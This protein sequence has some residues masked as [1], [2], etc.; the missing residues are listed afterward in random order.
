MFAKFLW[1]IWLGFCLSAPIG[2]IALLCIKNTL[3]RGRLYGLA[4]GMGAA[5]ADGIYGALA[6]CGLGM[7]LMTCQ[8]LRVI[9]NVV[10]GCYLLYLGYKF[11]TSSAA[12]HKH[13]LS[14]GSL[15]RT[16]LSTLLLTLLNPITI[17][18]FMALF[19]ALASDG[20]TPETVA[21]ASGVFAGSVIWYL[22]LA[23]AVSL[24]CGTLNRWIIW[25]NKVSGACIVAFGIKVL[26]G[27]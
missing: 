18:T 19:S 7:A 1:S 21:I 16:Y 3:E 4:A 9:C 14:Q 5:S 20:T 25:L 2:P 6:A 23:F 24:F 15:P 13:G 11:A 17:T 27:L 10:G 8:E 22:F 12:S 26:V